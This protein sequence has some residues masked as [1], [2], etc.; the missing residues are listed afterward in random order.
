MDNPIGAWADDYRP[1]FLSIL[2]IVTALLFL[3]HG[4]SKILGWPETSMSFPP[5]WTL[6]WIAGMLELVGGF[7]LL[8]GLLSRPVAFLLSGEMAI[9]YWMIHAPDSIFPVINRGEAAVLFCFVFLY[10]VFAGPGPWSVDEALRRKRIAD[11]P[12]GYYESGR[13]IADER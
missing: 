6:F 10:I 2:R 3:V 1:Q 8:F 4:T 5:P 9:A 12:D 11:G 13:M 7:L